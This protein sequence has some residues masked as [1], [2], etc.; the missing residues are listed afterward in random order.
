MSYY[1]ENRKKTIAILILFSVFYYLLSNS[2][3]AVMSSSNYW[4]KSDSINV[5]GAREGSASYR[6]EDTIGEI[7]SDESASASY[8]LK[9]GYQQMQEVYIAIS[10]P[11]DVVMSTAIP[12]ITGNAGAPRTGSATWTVITDNDAGFNLTHAASADPAMQLDATWYFSDYTSPTSTQPE[13]TWASPAVSAAEFG[14][15]VEPATA[16]DTVALFKD[17]GTAACNTGSNQTADK[18]WY[19]ASTT[20]LTIINR[21]TNTTSA[22]EAEVVKY[23]TESNV[24]YLKEGSYVATI[25]VTATAN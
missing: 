11:A 15:T 8:K 24:K 5:G 7:A 16:A 23:Q 1:S 4:I 10:S 9:A 19:S 12:G 6:M 21:S 13:Y 18:C 2:V 20:A 25:T 3:Q 14:Q 22:G 17:D